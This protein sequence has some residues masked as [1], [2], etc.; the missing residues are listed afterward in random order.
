MQNKARLVAKG[1]SQQEGI[2]YTKTFA[3]VSRL[4]AIRIL[5]SFAAHT[6]MRLCQM[7]YDWIPT[8]SNC[9]QTR[10]IV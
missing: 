10:H 2:N 3:L 5:L 9:V 6:K 4:E 1:Y 7:D 8:I